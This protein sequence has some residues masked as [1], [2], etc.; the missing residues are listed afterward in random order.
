MRS[1]LTHSSICPPLAVVG[2][3]QPA[4]QA[5]H[6]AHDDISA[7]RLFQEKS[8]GDAV[9]RDIAD[10]MGDRVLDRVDAHALPSMAMLP[11]S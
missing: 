10:P 9:F 7:D 11:P 2:Q 8:L 1:A 5:I 4:A 6:G 3:P